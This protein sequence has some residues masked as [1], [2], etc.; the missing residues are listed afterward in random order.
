MHKTVCISEAHEWGL[1]RWTGPLEEKPGEACVGL[2]ELCTHL[3]SESCMACNPVKP[4]KHQQKFVNAQ[5]FKKCI[6]F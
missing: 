2:G 1:G 6:Y 3:G 4:E 5:L